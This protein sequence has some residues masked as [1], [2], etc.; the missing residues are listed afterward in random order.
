MWRYSFVLGVLIVSRPTLAVLA[1]EATA[2]VAVDEH[3]TPNQA[4][5]PQK[6]DVEA[7]HRAA[8]VKGLEWIARQQCSTCHDD[9]H[10]KDVALAA[11]WLGKQECVRCHFTVPGKQA[12][13]KQ[14]N[15]NTNTDFF[16]RSLADA[17]L[18]TT[19]GACT[20]NADRKNTVTYLG[21]GVSPVPELL[22]RHVKLPAEMCLLVES[23]EPDSPAKA[24]GVEQY[25]ILEKINEQ[26]LVNQEQFSALI[27][28]YRPGTQIT[29]TLVRGN[30]TQIV[31][32]TLAEREAAAGHD[33][34]DVTNEAGLTFLDYDNDDL[35]AGTLRHYVSTGNGTFIDTHSGFV[36][37]S[38]VQD[39]ES[40]ATPKEGEQPVG[41]QVTYLGV[42]TSS[43]P[44]ALAGQ[45]K[46]PAGLFLLV[47]GV[48]EGSP[49]AAAGVRSAD[50]LQQLDDQVLVNSDQMGVLI[51]GRKAGDEVTLTLIREGRQT[52]IRAQLGQRDAPAQS[53]V[54][55]GTWVGSHLATQLHTGATAGFRD[56]ALGGRWAYS[57]WQDVIE[58]KD[59]SAAATSDEEFVRRVYLD[60]VGTPPTAEQI[61]EFTDDARADKRK[62]LFDELLARPDVF[63]KFKGVSSLEWSDAE[64]AL[65]LTSHEG[66]GRHLVAKGLS[67]SVVFD[68]QVDTDEERGQL[69]TAIAAK[70]ALMLRGI[71]RR[72]APPNAQA[73]LERVISI[74]A[75]EAGLKQVVDML[76]KETGANI[77]VNAKALK[78]AGADLDGP[79]TFELRDVTL[80]TA[81]KTIAMLMDGDRRA[82]GYTVEDDV[83]MIS[84]K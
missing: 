57:N 69:P 11:T 31:S 17:A 84:A 50:V 20:R 14:A 66:G 75:S 70:L 1:Q 51:R 82:V 18:N 53:T 48:D 3:A 49:A 9:P 42:Q 13:G 77:V 33:F 47:D 25:D 15:V 80:A 26:L 81:L 58:L 78:T 38:A 65:H 43:P 19:H 30:Q 46:L 4:T 35:I 62:A 64:H 61:H 10:G 32:A 8:V 27:R 6:T 76:R 60:L 28:S 22:R 36:D 5:E 7:A 79:L 83:I 21:V 34:T 74:T 44:P 12:P 55:Y 23:V 29:L 59:G 52:T 16:L 71:D 45:L 41:H 72:L 39:I 56:A 67:G 73:L 24:A 2:P 40:A 37:G 54:D 68:G 63:S